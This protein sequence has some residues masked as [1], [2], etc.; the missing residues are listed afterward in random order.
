M[1]GM[2]KPKIMEK[3]LTEENEDIIEEEMN[4]LDPK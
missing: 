1:R 2:I 3:T 4:S